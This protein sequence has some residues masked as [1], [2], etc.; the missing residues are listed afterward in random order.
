MLERG[1]GSIVNIASMSGSIV[2][3]PQPQAAYT[4]SNEYRDLQGGRP[5]S[6]VVSNDLFSL[7]L[8]GSF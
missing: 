3:K 6:G 5:G 8:T 7:Q 1:S 2:N 4:V